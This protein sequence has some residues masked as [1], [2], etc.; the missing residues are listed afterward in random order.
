MNSE[1]ILQHLI[2]VDSNS[3]LS[4]RDQDEQ[5]VTEMIAL[6]KKRH[7]QQIEQRLMIKKLSL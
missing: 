2:I 4:I 5:F 6:M 1:Q 3:S 7:L